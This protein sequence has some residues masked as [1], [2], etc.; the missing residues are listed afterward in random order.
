MSIFII[1]IAVVIALVNLFAFFKAHKAT[2]IAQKALK[3]LKG[4]PNFSPGLVDCYIKF[5]G[6]V[7]PDNVYNSPVNN[8]RCAFYSYF[9]IAHWTHKKKKP[10]KGT[11]PQKRLLLQDKS[12]ATLELIHKSGAI[13][14]LGW[15]DFLIRDKFH[16]WYTHKA[17]NTICPSTCQ[18]L[19]ENRFKKYESIENYLYSGEE[20]VVYG[21]LIRVNNGDLYITHSKTT[22]YPS[23]LQLASSEK[24]VLAYSKEK[25]SS[26]IRKRNFHT[27]LFLFFTFIAIFVFYTV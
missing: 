20:I 27:A 14:K 13:V 24:S 4:A 10:G 7:K 17:K 6:K 2:K 16:Y 8:T 1:F 9:V 15:E 26:K 19:A 22:Q 3:H 12:A 5:T 18:E 11:E 23:S 25:L 21:K